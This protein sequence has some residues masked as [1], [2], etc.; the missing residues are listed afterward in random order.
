MLPQ[1]RDRSP[2]DPSG[3][4]AGVQECT[5][6]GMREGEMKEVAQFM[7][8][9]ALRAEEPARIRAEV[10]AFKRAFTQVHFCFH[11]GFDAYKYHKLI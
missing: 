2:Q 7:A 11:G 6:V 3:V 10:S 5:R 4:R 1:D 9:A 8:R